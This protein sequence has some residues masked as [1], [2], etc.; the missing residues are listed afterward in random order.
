MITLSGEELALISGEGVVLVVL[1]LVVFFV[2]VPPPCATA[3]LVA[4]AE[5]EGL[6]VALLESVLAETVGLGDGL[7]EADA[8]A[9]AVT[10]GLEDPW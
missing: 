1:E 8:L 3:P 5:T 9:D 10:A 6:V 2:V 4:A 7:L